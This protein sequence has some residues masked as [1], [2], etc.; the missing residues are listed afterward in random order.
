[1]TDTIFSPAFGNK[2]GKLVGRDLELKCLIEG[3]QVRPGNKERARLIIGQRGLGKTVLL[4]ELAEYARKHGFIVASPTVVSGDMLDRILEKLYRDGAKHLHE[5]KAALTGGSI[6]ILGFSA[7]VQTEKRAEPK[8]SFAYQLLDICEKARDSGK[9]ILILVDEVQANNEELKKLII[10]YQEM[11]GEGQNIAIV[12]AGLPA[13]VS[14]ALNQ[15][16]LTFFNRASKLFLNPI[17][18]SEISVYYR[19]CFEAL[20]I[21]LKDEWID[22][23]SEETGG[24][25]YMMQLVGH[26]ITISSSDTGE[27][28]EESFLR[29]LTLA[30]KEFIQDICETTLSPLSERDIA[31]LR[32]MATDRH[33]SSV[34]EI[35][36]LLGVDSSYVQRYKTRLSQAG[37]IQQKRRGFVEF[38]VPYLR[39][40]LQ[41]DEALS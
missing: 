16:V 10:A 15:H 39:E 4:L 2:P 37:I 23:A 1:M 24:S 14:K 18:I 20:G 17:P 40:Y 41:T 27:L 22:R 35:G 12:F 7:G 38:A 11:V 28:Q 25:P 21:R 9:G 5:E 6:G 33:E 30:K 29:A 34:K 3:L 32:A 31:F 13:A 26:Y 36:S 8:R 19:S